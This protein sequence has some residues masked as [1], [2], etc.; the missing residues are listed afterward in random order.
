MG[1]TW[2]SELSVDLTGLVRR[3]PGCHRTEQVTGF[4][5]STGRGPVIG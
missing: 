1:T 2:R 3:M 4:F 5:F